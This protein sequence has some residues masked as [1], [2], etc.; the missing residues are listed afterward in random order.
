MRSEVHEEDQEWPGI[1]P[2]LTQLT[3]SALA[4][5]YG[6]RI[7]LAQSGGERAS[8]VRDYA[9]ECLRELSGLDTEEA[10]SLRVLYRAIERG[11]GA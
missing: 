10:H 1:D 5:R 8:L 9:K 6:D 7:A 11:A 2:A 4:A 3:L